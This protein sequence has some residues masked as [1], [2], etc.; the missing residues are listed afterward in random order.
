MFFTYLRGWTVK[1][2]TGL[3][4]AQLR[5]TVSAELATGDSDEPSVY[6]IR[7]T[8]FAFDDVAHLTIR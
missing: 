4:Q 7:L 3:D 6:T 8:T 5:I 2:A 1:N